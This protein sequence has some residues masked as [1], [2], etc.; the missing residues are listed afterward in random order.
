[1][2]LDRYYIYI[3]IL[4]A[5]ASIV[6]LFW[7]LDKRATNVRRITL[8]AVMIA[9][10]ISSRFIFAAIPAFKPMAAIII[11]TGM[12]LGGEA[13]FLC[14]S[15]TAFL[16]NFYF[17]QGPWT[18]FQ[19]LAFGIIGLSAHLFS[20]QLKKHRASL[21]IF[22]LIAGVF[23]SFFL[24][25]WTMLW[26]YGGLNSDG[27]IAALYTAIPYTLLYAASNIIF[28]LL[29]HKPFGQRIGRIIFKYKI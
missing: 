10:S 24:D 16:S 3:S 9:L 12:Y 2:L 21:A 11:L 18:P 29:L 23:Y 27:Y 14:G 19:M 22:G 26:T 5:L 7:R 15:L 13:G 28:L 25:I 6:I 4:I 17:G 8:I 1:M 20:K